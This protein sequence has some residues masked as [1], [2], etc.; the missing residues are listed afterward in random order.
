[1]QVSTPTAIITRC[2]INPKGNEVPKEITMSV[3][4]WQMP[5]FQQDEKQKDHF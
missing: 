2:F 1:M 4:M 5:R 3:N